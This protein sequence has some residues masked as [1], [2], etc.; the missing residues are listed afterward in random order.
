ML[1]AEEIQPSLFQEKPPLM[2]VSESSLD[3]S[4]DTQNKMTRKLEVLRTYWDNLNDFRLRR[5]KARKY[6]RGDQWHESITHPDTGAQIREDDYIAELGKTPLKNNQIRQLVKNL[7]GQFIDNRKKSA[8]FSRKREEQSSSEMMTNALLRVHDINRVEKLDVR[9]F[10][11]FLISGAFG[12]RLSYEWFRERNINDVKIKMID[13]TRMF[14]NTDIKDP[15]LDDMTCIGQIHDI[16]L[17]EIQSKFAQSEEDVLKIKEWYSSTDK[18]DYGQTTEF[19]SW[20][21][22]NLDFYVPTNLNKGRVYE[23]WELKKVQKMMVHDYADGSLFQ[24]DYTEEDIIQMNNERMLSA[25]QN[26]IPIEQVD[27]IVGKFEMED[28][29]HYI[30]LTPQG[31]VLASGESQYDHEHH[32]FSLT[33]YPMVDSDVWGFVEDIIDQQKA[34]NRYFTMLDFML[35]SGSKGVLMIPEEIIPDGWDEARFAEEWTKFN[36]VIA[37]K[38]KPGVPLPQQI[39]SNS[40]SVAGQQLLSIQLELLKDISGVHGAIQGKEAQSGV[41]GTL[42]AQMANNA[43]I[44][45]KDY[46][47]TFYEGTRDRDFKIVQMIQ[48]MYDEKRYI[49]ITGKDYEEEAMTYDP[50][51]AK[52]TDY[53]VVIGHSA[54]TPVHRQM[55][56]EWLINMFDK[57]AIDIKMLLE[58]SSLPNADK[59]LQQISQKEQKMQSQPI[60]DPVAQQFLGQRQG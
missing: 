56:D 16:E 31:N 20:E 35:G 14:W 37:Y 13:I 55:M 43:S 42:Y 21:T 60:Q 52:R 44:S 24:T 7:L 6:Y 34:I 59:L 17:D 46:F 26:G 22:D 8:V 53:D 25:I 3:D 4:Q 49:N 51:R 10:E 39:T 30:F 18:Y 1:N 38:A 19:G 50:D 54:N 45:N 12:W 2:K 29:W 40:T 58:N 47:S 11:E 5:E 33:L 23:V 32:P 41:S 9:M 57:G 27:P 36:G 48:Q 15:R 28:V